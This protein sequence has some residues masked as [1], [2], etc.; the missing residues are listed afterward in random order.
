MTAA[1]GNYSNAPLTYHRIIESFKFAYAWRGELGDPA[2]N[3]DSDKVMRPR[4]HCTGEIIL[5]SF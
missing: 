4:L 1:S 2:F 5:K 3:N